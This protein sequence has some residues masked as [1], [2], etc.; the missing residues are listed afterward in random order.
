MNHTKT[1]T[2]GIATAIAT[3]TLALVTAG[4]VVSMMIPTIVQTAHASCISSPK[5]F[6]CSGGGGPCL[7][8]AGGSCSLS[9][10]NGE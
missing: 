6:A 10:A 5:G 9:T 7:G 2:M 1:T 3:V 4:I 8:G